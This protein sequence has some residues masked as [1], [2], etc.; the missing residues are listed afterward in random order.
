MMESIIFQVGQNLS[1]HLG[2]PRFYSIIIRREVGWFKEQA[3]EVR[4]E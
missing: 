4:C 2:G 1:A 3:Q